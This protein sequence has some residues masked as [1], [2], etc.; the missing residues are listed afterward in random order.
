ML[1]RKIFIQQGGAKTTLDAM[2]SYSTMHWLT[3]ASMLHSTLK[4]Q[5]HLMSIYWI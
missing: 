2:R 4:Q 1:S 3:M 5:T